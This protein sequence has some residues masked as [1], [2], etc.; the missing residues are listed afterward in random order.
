MLL[1]CSSLLIEMITFMN[2]CI[3]FVVGTMFTLFES[4]LFPAVTFFMRFCSC[5]VL[6]GAVVYRCEQSYCQSDRIVCILNQMLFT[7]KINKEMRTPL[8]ELHI[9]VTSRPIR[10]YGANYFLID[11][12][13]LVST[14]SFVVTFTIIL[15]D[16]L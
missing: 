16:N 6:L 5:I 10:F 11:Y 3:R 2:V 9:L 14:A 15:L 13:L 4:N 12:K 8:K 1:I 7:R